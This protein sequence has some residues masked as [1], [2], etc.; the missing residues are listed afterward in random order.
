M[1]F[2]TASHSQVSCHFSRIFIPDMVQLMQLKFEENSLHVQLPSSASKHTQESVYWI[3]FSSWLVENLARNFWA[4][5]RRSA[6]YTNVKKK[7]L[8]F[9]SSLNLKS[10]LTRYYN[11]CYFIG[12]F[13]WMD[14]KSSFAVI[15]LFAYARELLPRLVFAPPA[16]MNPDLF[17]RVGSVTPLLCVWK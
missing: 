16:H 17:I 8:K 6:K 13:Y 7:V 10:A 1:D 14:L 5:Y 12:A 9:L 4:Y 2:T 11:K 15:F 3:C